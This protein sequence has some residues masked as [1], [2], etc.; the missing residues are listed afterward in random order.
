MKDASRVCVCSYTAIISRANNGRVVFGDGRRISKDS[1]VSRDYDDQFL[2]SGMSNR[3]AFVYLFVEHG[4]NG[5]R[6]S[7]VRCL[8][9]T[10]LHVSA[11]AAKGG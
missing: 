6:Q 8:E 3:I 10:P 9:V 1:A 5:F 4:G 2:A 11:E 7:T